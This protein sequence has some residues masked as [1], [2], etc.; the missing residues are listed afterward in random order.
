M[1]SGLGTLDQV[2]QAVSEVSVAGAGENRGQP[3]G[4]DR[5]EQLDGPGGGDHL[6]EALVE[7]FPRAGPGRRE[8]R[9]WTLEDVAGLRL[10]PM[11]AAGTSRSGAS[12]RAGSQWMTV[13]ELTEEATT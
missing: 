8:S 13:A 2:K 11:T 4:A 9:I 5:V 6:V 1:E 3:G 10:P 12:V 7:V